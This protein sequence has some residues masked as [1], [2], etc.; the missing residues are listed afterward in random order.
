MP[1]IP[2]SQLV[3]PVGVSPHTYP[4]SVEATRIM[5]L[6]PAFR[7]TRA[8]EFCR[9]VFM[10]TLVPGSGPASLGEVTA[11]GPIHIVA[12]PYPMRWEIAPASPPPVA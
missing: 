5:F 9:G 8:A 4:G 12:S 2:S 3:K 11:G 10:K 6:Y 1:G 7:T